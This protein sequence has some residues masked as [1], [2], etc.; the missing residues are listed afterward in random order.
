MY[1]F[2][3]HIVIVTT[4]MLLYIGLCSLQKETYVPY[5]VN[6]YTPTKLYVRFGYMFQGKPPIQDRIWFSIAC[7]LVKE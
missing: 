6:I 7:I 2:I 4:F 1:I 3:F 5:Q